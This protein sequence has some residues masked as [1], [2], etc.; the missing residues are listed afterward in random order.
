M[1]KFLNEA[2]ASGRLIVRGS[3]SEESPSTTESG[4]AGLFK[5]C[6]ELIDVIDGNGIA[7][8]TVSSSSEESM[9]ITE[10]GEEDLDSL[11]CPLPKCV[12]IRDPAW[13]RLMLNGFGEIVA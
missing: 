11:T 4:V 2:R 8:E 3:S 10:S 1:E 12:V 9:T 7:A 13:S 5:A 6:D